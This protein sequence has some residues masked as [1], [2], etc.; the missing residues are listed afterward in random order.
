[1]SHVDIN[2]HKI[3]E[4][5]WPTLI[6]IYVVE[7]AADQRLPFHYGGCSMVAFGGYYFSM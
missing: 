4:M 1:M 2:L 3:S 6:N 5:L 7:V